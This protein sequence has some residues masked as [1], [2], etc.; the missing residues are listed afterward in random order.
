M[1][2]VQ[3]CALPIWCIEVLVENGILDE[4]QLISNEALNLAIDCDDINHIEKSYYFKSAILQKLGH[5]DKADMYMN[6]STD[7]LF[8]YA[9]NQERYERYMEMGNMYY[10]MGDI[11][12]AIKYFTLAI[13]LQKKI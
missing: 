2:G 1:T 5:Y 12:E 8:K 6:L 11:S 13:S 4:A 3:T 9:N 10:K 7:A